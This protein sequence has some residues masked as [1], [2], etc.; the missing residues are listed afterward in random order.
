LLYGQ[1]LL[2]HIHYAVSGFSLIVWNCRATLYFGIVNRF[3]FMTAQP[4]TGV[5]GTNR[6]ST[7]YKLMQPGL[8]LPDDYLWHVE[9]VGSRF[10]AN[11]L[12][13]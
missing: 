11:F 4:P 5:L 1:A 9:K 6:K 12:K 8:L 13:P 3:A 2:R 7:M 10:I